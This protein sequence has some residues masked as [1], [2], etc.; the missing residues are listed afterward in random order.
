MIGAILYWFLFAIL[1]AAIEV[2]AEGKNGWAE[3][4][5]TWY[6]T[7][8]IGGRLYGLLMGGKP[9]T[10]YHLFMFFLPLV[11]VHVGFFQGVR[12]TISSELIV[13]ARYFALTVLW[14]YLWFILNPH[15][16]FSKFRRENVWW[17]QKSY[18]V[19]NRFPIDYAIGWILSLG[20]TYIA[21]KAGAPA[22]L[23]EHI[24][25]LIGLLVL[26]IVTICLS[27]FY[28]TWYWRMRAHDDRDDAGIH[29]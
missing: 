15:Y 1:L 9:L 20:L 22:A 18:W 21:T 25:I 28:H 17:H 5:P 10:G 7:R 4:M 6:R 27:T 19:F 8:G 3:K 2:E 29:H 11:A 13:L 24:L 16:G 12:W 26:T 14:D 23:Q